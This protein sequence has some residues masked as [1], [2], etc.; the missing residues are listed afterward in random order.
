MRRGRHQDLRKPRAEIGDGD[1]GGALA[2]AELDGAVRASSAT[3]CTDWF[4]RSMPT[5][6]RVHLRRIGVED[7]GRHVEA[8]LLALRR[9]AQLLDAADDP[10]AAS[11]R[12]W[13]SQPR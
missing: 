5:G 12:P 6:G 3:T 4:L 11:R 10:C 8:R 9:L 2:I 1:P 7:D 13:R